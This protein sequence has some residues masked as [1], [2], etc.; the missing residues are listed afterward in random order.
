M[1]IKALLIPLLIVTVSYSGTQHI[2][3][4]EGVDGA[5]LGRSHLIDVEKAFPNGILHKDSSG[6]G[7][8]TVSARW[9]DGSSSAVKMY[10]EKKISYTYS[11]KDEGIFF[12]FNYGDTL[13]HITIWD[14]NKYATDKG[15]I[16]GK[17]T[18]HDLDSIYGT[19]DW[20]YIFSYHKHAYVW[21][22]SYK[23]IYFNA[24]NRKGKNPSNTLIIDNIE[25]VAYY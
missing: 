13:D 15:I 5:K 4:E 16:L 25:I 3:S 8:Q 17:S 1:T 20:S 7:V 24:A 19:K 2:I 18:F 23:N 11:I 22:K 10:R 21:T 6:G 9:M 12:Y 14:K